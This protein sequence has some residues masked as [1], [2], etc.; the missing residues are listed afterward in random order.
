MRSKERE[1]DHRV[2]HP[3]FDD[4]EDDERR[5]SPE[6]RCERAPRRD[7]AGVRRLEER[8]HDRPEPDRR[9]ESSRHVDVRGGL[10]V[11]GVSGTWRLA[12]SA[13]ATPTGRLKKNSQRQDACATTQPPATG[14]IADA[15]DV[16][17]D[18]VPIAAP[19]DASGYAAV[20]SARLPGTSSAAP[21]P[22][23]GSRDDEPRQGM[24]REAACR[25][26][27]SEERDPGHE[28]APA[29]EP[30]AE[31]AADEDERREEERVGLDDP[32]RP[33]HAGAET[34]LDQ[35]GGRR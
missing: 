27:E 28:D 6:Q 19:R 9:E 3:R 33:V 17:A 11:A 31:R 2:A 35:A 12:R 24:G 20:M 21:D 15:I 13:V 32:L 8:P 34:L 10:L 22:L 4:D 5:H 1:R 25:R 18:H 30:I 26:S 7:P 14:A 23:H 29:T 16:A